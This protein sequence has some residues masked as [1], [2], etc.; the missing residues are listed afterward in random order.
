MNIK[1]GDNVKILRG[2]DRGKNGKVLRVFP[3]KAKLIVENMNLV[4]RH[5]KAR[6]TNEQSER[7]TVPAPIS[8]SNV[9][10]ICPKCS[11]PT[12]LSLKL[13]DGKKVRVCKKCQAEI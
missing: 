4:K 13:I 9:Q 7:M 1:K 10:F 11:K 8:I 2:K 12:R 6:N 5:R 3:K